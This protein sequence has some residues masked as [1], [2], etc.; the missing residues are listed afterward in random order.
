MLGYWASGARRV[1][2]RDSVFPP[3]RTDEQ[4]QQ[5]NADQFAA[6]EANAEVAAAE[7]AGACRP[8]WWSASWSPDS[9]AAGALAGRRRAGRG[10]RPPGGLARGG[11]RGAGQHRAGPVGARSPTGGPASSATPTWCSARARTARRGCSASGPGSSRRPATSRISLGD[12]GG[13][14]AGLMFALAVVDKLTP[15]ELTGGRFVAGTGTITPTAWCRPDR[16]HPV[17]DARRAGGRGHRV[18]GARG[19]L[20]GG[21]RQRA[22]RAAAAA[23]GHPATTRSP[24][25]DRRCAPRQAPGGCCTRRADSSDSSGRGRTPGPNGNPTP[26]P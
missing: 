22:G 8:G 12:I 15:G 24:A 26:R 13:P 17:Q 14:S 2:P 11:G 1:V 5:D 21:G 6:S 4:V 23:G 20:R 19:Q 3:G 16:R 7:P 25:L 10:V 18:P 9:P